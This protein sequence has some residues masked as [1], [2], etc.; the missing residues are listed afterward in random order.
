VGL[1]SPWVIVLAARIV[2]Y[3][4]LI[5]AVDTTPYIVRMEYGITYWAQV[6]SF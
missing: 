5:L 6:A 4:V 2:T 1:D 3:L